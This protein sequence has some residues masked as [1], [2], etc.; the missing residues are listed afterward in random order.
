MRVHESGSSRY[1]VVFLILKFIYKKLMSTL[2]LALMVAYLAYVAAILIYL[3]RL[4][5]IDLAFTLKDP[6]DVPEKWQP[7]V[8][9]DRHKWRLW[10]IYLGALTLL[11]MRIIMFVS[12]MVTWGAF[13]WALSLG[14]SKRIFTI[15]YIGLDSSR[16]WPAMRFRI[17][18]A[19]IKWCARFILVCAFG[20]YEVKHVRVTGGEGFIKDHSCP[21]IVSNHTSWFDTIILI[22]H[23]VPSF[24]AKRDVQSTPIVAQWS[25]FLRCIYVTRESQGNRSDAV[26]HIRERIEAVQAGSH[27]PP[28]LIFP[29]GT[30]S[31]GRYVLPFKRG[32]FSNLQP[33]KVVCL[34]YEDGY[35]NLALDNLGMAAILL[36]MT[37]LSN[38]GTLYEFEGLFHPAYLKD[39]SLS[40]EE[41]V[42]VHASIICVGRE[43]R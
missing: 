14:I 32:A 15:L 22:R 39:T 43:I 40:E 38:K 4:L 18:N 29:E 30:T 24:L 13:N 35:F 16:E 1:R 6:A 12:A 33:V 28:L 42:P 5:R 36:A 2:I 31:N 9:Y 3:H 11:P 17:F 19:N 37:Q 7:F 8:R 27:L 26:E 21:L 41:R 25:A 20:F 10:E 23:F 34:R